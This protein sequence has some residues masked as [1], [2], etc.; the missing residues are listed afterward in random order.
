M[1][2]SQN[3]TP[4]H[5]DR[6]FC[7]LKNKKILTTTDHCLPATDCHFDS[8]FSSLKAFFVCNLAMSCDPW[9]SLRPPRRKNLSLMMNLCGK[10][11]VKGVVLFFHNRLLVVL[12]CGGRLLPPA[13]H[14]SCRQ[15]GAR[16]LGARARRQHSEAA[17]APPSKAAAVQIRK[18]YTVDSP[19]P[20]LAQRNAVDKT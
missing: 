7:L 5:C 15:D 10:G 18:Y 4:W 1:R 3:G 6:S 17:A 13:Q 16:L 8:V 11:D 12:C 9:H 2:L 14:T 19:S 20:V